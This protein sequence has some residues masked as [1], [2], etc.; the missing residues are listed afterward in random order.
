MATQNEAE[1]QE[2]LLSWSP[3]CA[4]FWAAQV[5]A[6]LHRSISGSADAVR[7]TA[8]QAP[9]WVHDTPVNRSPATVPGTVVCDQVVPF[10]FQARTP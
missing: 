6:P 5:P 4:A 10:H 7:P 3:V 2:T 8:V 9:R 1:V